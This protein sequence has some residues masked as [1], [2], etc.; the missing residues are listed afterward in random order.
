[1]FM[2]DSKN[3]DVEKITGNIASNIKMADISLLNFTKS[4]KNSLTDIQGVINSVAGYNTIAAN[5]AR[6]TMGSTRI[7]GNAIQKASAAAA[8]NTLLVGK[9][10]EDNIKLYGA[11]NESMMRLTFFSDKQI[12]AFQILGF[13]ANMSAAELATMATS[14][15]TLGYTTD[16][17]LE[18]MKGMTK[19]ARSYGL[20]V[21][22]FM[23]GVN[24]NLKL[25][26]SYNFKDGVKGL[27]NMVAQAQALRIDMGTT[28][29]LA[30]KL[31]SPEA[32]IE[33]AAGF[34]MLGGA[35]GKLG[36]P[37][38]LLH[39]AQT[40]MEGLQDS[41]VGMAAASVNFN[42]KTGEFNIPVTEM[43]RLR[44][45]A[46][47][48]GMSYQE[49]TELAMKAAQKT[50]KLDILGNMNSVP[51]EQK[52]L[53]ANMSKIGANG[54]LEITMP[55]GTVKKI[56]EG[57][58]DLTANDYTQLEKMLD[59]NK[60]SEL[61]VA[62]ESMG[63]LNQ[64]EAAQATLVKLTTLNLVKSG[65]FENFAEDAAKAQDL[66]TTEFLKREEEI[67]VPQKIVDMA[68][69]VETQLKLDD[70]TAKE[71]VAAVVTGISTASDAISRG[72]EEA[73]K[74]ANGEALLKMMQTGW[75][76]VTGYLDNIDT[77]T[78]GIFKS[79]LQRN[80]T[81]VQNVNEESKE[82]LP[83]G[84]S[85]QEGNETIQRNNLSVSNLNTSSLNV[86]EPTTSAIASNSNLT[87]SGQVNLTV[88]NMPTSS[89]MTKEEFARYLINN[90]DA[91]A[92]IS[93]QLLN[94][95]GTYGGSVTGGGMNS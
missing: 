56:G 30:D 95:N 64:I 10:V 17:T 65:G 12:E 69:Q 84:N 35:I 7:V 87:V 26:T 39:M 57:F 13:T 33:T 27:S 94:T 3:G 52:E 88:D 61:D 67:K 90:P 37:F 86:N 41:V 70:D 68:G 54:N 72:L 80:N 60:M 89:V 25:M 53:I 85:G 59:V 9:G 71:I 58:N 47:L 40:D 4:L 83:R 23:G 66:L 19:Q 36:D 14:F 91:M 44:E 11:L 81:G 28:V 75:D 21:S 6:E 15:D 31:M 32:A 46:D 74:A 45:A 48:A 76:D 1:M 38:Q 2:F 34:Q 24:K 92:T 49:M 5:T 93:S 20:N 51:E 18:T 16:K 79:T 43:Y 8:E 82:T 55:D 50:K 22:E 29:S 77:S 78:D 62:K 42:E 73:L 63:Y